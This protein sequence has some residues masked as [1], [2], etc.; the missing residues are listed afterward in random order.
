[1]AEQVTREQ[2]V[3]GLNEDLSHEYQAVVM[4][5]TY[6][7]LSS[8]IHRP[9]LKGFFEEE[10]P[11]ELNHAKFLADKITA[12]GGTPV[13]RVPEVKIT[14]DTREMLNEVHTAESETIERYVRRRHQAEAFGD[15]GLAADL[16]EI[17][18]DETRHKEETA[19][20]MMGM[21]E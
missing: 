4:Y 5:T 13:T 17:I 3:E 19:K 12:L 14:R 1:M 11:D 10:I 15:Y 2:L 6:A 9:L 18:S 20:L 7:A 16:D 8:G 21:R